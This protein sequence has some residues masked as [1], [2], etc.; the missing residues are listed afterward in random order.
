M[1]RSFATASFIA[2]LAFGPLNAIAAETPPQG[3]TLAQQ[4]ADQWRSSKLVGV[5]I[6][7]PD[8]KSVGKITDML[9]GK[10]G[11][12]AFVVIGVGGFLGIGEKDVAVPFDAVDFSEK[13]PM[14][15]LA[16]PM[17]N[18][19]AATNTSTN[20]AMTNGTASPAAGG[21]PVVGGG[22][23]PATSVGLGSSNDAAGNVMAPAGGDAMMAPAMA[24]RSTAYPDHGTI[25]MNKDQLKQAPSFQ[26]VR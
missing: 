11:K 19:L 2:L 3:T 25:A 21:Q 15:Q 8:N 4:S 14:P 9:M 6:Y 23:A 20:G 5:S 13:P 1:Q 22:M 24:A 17:A 26:F 18:N 10:D 16:M 12:V 7:G